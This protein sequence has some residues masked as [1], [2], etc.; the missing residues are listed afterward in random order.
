MPV[1]CDDETHSEICSKCI[2]S[3]MQRSLRV[4]CGT[5]LVCYTSPS[6]GSSE[7]CKLCHHAVEWNDQIRLS[8]TF[9]SLEKLQFGLPRLSACHERQSYLGMLLLGGAVF[10][11]YWRLVPFAFEAPTP[12]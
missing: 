6:T 3:S 12:A 10:A 4:W 8:G 7:E 5:Y 1:L 2:P 9:R 11:G